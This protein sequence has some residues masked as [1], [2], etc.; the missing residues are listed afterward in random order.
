MDKPQKINYKLVDNLSLKIPF[1][2]YK[3]VSKFHAKFPKID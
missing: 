2:Y 1:K 3:K